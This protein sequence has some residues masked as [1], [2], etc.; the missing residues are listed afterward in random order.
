MKKTVNPLLIDNLKRLKEDISEFRRQHQINTSFMILDSLC[1]TLLCGKHTKV[2]IDPIDI[3]MV[4]WAETDG[5]FKEEWS[6]VEAKNN[7]AYHA[8]KNELLKYLKM[9]NTY[10]QYDLILNYPKA[11]IVFDGNKIE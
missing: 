4:Y 3:D 9:I 2:Y 5:D 7:A 6:V 8:S 11:P 1:E 10:W